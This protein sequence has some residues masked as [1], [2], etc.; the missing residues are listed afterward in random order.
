MLHKGLGAMSALTLSASAASLIGTLQGSEYPRGT[1]GLWIATVGFLVLGIATG[2]AWLMTR[3]DSTTSTPHVASVRADN[4]SVAAGGN[5][6]ATGSSHIGPLTNI[7]TYN[8]APPTP[9]QQRNIDQVIRQLRAKIVREYPDSQLRDVD[10]ASV[11]ERAAKDLS[12]GGVSVDP[13]RTLGSPMPYDVLP[14]DFPKC[15]D[16]W[17][18]LGIVESSDGGTYHL[19]DFGREVRNRLVSSIRLSEPIHFPSETVDPPPRVHGSMRSVKLWRVA[20]SVDRERAQAKNVKVH[21]ERASP[22]ITFLPVVAHAMRDNLARRDVWNLRYG[23]PAVLFDIISMEDEPKSPERNRRLFIYRNDV[24]DPYELN[25]G[26]SS[27]WWTKWD[28]GER[29]ELTITAVPDVPESVMSATYEL[30]I[31]DAG[32][33]QM[34]TKP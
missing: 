22:A 12:L 17:Q 27:P 25:E 4:S 11:L 15:L 24:D 19:T 18:Y 16:H 8:A 14:D 7:E 28:Q 34:R 30:W 32:E 3:D 31:D 1:N 6:T 23:E 21:I 2:I 26:E 5:M 10:T 13:H 9:A 29:V 20:V 33:L